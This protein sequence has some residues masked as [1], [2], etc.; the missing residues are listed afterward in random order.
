[1]NDTIPSEIVKEIQDLLAKAAGK[2]NRRLPNDREVVI[3]TLK[4]NYIDGAVEDDLEEISVVMEGKFPET[5]LPMSRNAHEEISI[6][7]QKGSKRSRKVKDVGIGESS[8]AREITDPCFPPECCP[9]IPGTW[10][11]I[12]S[13]TMCR[14]LR[15]SHCP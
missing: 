12:I 4:I 13:P 9:D 2:A 14:C 10:K 11:R 1:M 3:C 5:Q 8:E 7:D 6:Y 15:T